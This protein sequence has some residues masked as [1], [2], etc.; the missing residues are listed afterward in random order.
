MFYCETK[1]FCPVYNISAMSSWG[2]ML[3]SWP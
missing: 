1:E 2:C 3:W